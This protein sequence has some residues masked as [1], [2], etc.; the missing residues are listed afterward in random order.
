MKIIR[1]I[2]FI[3]ISLII[4]SHTYACDD[5]FNFVVETNSWGVYCF[6]VD[7]IGDNLVCRYKN[8]KIKM[9]IQKFKPN[10]LSLQDPFGWI[11]VFNRNGCLD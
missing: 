9:I 2:I 6:D 8:H 4:Y 5:P 3:L 1:L 11:S 7:L 10:P